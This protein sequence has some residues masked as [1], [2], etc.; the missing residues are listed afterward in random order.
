MVSLNGTYQADP[1][2][3]SSFTPVP[4]GI[5][6]VMLVNSKMNSKN[7]GISCEFDIVSGEYQGR[8]LFTNLS[9]F[10]E[11]K[12]AAEIAQ[13]QLNDMCVATGKLA[14]SDTSELHGITMQAKVKLRKDD[15]TQNDITGFMPLDGAAQSQPVT[16]QTAPVTTGATAPATGNA[17]PPWKRP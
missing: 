16:S 4:A 2:A 1:N 15:A 6:Q 3:V 8:K 7:T 13:R 10:S 5:Y 12:T 9:L 11:N 17:P 14:I